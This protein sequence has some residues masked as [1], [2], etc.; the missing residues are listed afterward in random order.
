MIKRRKTKI[1]RIG[2]L[3]IGGNF[4]VLVQSMTNTPTSNVLA[5]I[6][7]IKKLD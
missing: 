1:V 6:K 3:K 7:Q 4:P 2:N 5:T